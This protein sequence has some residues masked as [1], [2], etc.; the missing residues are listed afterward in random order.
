MLERAKEIVEGW[1][2]LATGNE[3]VKAEA[4]RRAAICAVCPLSKYDQILV[5]TIKDDIEEIRGLICGECGCPLSPKVRSKT[6]TCPK[7]KWIE[8][9]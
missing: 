3:A 8:K 6:S 1:A 7:D 4:K 5:W 2:N 9:K